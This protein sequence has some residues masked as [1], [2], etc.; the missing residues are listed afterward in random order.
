M[1]LLLLLSIACAPPAEDSSPVNDSDAD[2]DTDTDADSD[3]DSDA[4]TDA[5]AD[6]DT[7]AETTGIH[8]SGTLQ[9]AAF[10]ADCGLST[11]VADYTVRSDYKT[12]LN[13]NC[14]ETTASAGPFVMLSIISDQ[15][16]T[17][18][19]CVNAPGSATLLIG[20]DSPQATDSC[21]SGSS[22]YSVKLDAF[23]VVD[24]THT[25]FAGTFHFVSTSGS[26]SVDGTFDL[27][28][29]CTSGC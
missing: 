2:A 17:F 11:V 13:I 16:G 18:T 10:S 6:T 25:A 14:H 12:Q 27:T 19:N 22:E 20:T 8:A 1:S 15:E 9:G 28:G 3:A 4:D 21:V 23:T 29:A 26:T 7:D 24:D 5:D